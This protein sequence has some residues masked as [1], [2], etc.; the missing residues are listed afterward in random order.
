MIMTQLEMTLFYL[1]GGLLFAL[2]AGLT[3]SQ[4]FRTGVLGSFALGLSA[5]AIITVLLDA[6]SGENYQFL[7]QTGLLVA[8]FALFLL[9][10][11]W[12]AWYH[13][14]VAPHTEDDEVIVFQPRRQSTPHSVDARGF[15]LLEFLL[16]LLLLLGLMVGTQW[17]ATQNYRRGFEAGE[18]KERAAAQGDRDRAQNDYA[19]QVQQLQQRLVLRERQ[20]HQDAARALD[21]LTQEKDNALK[22]KDDVIAA[23]RNGSGSLQFYHTPAFT[24]PCVGYDCVTIPVTISPPGAAR[25]PDSGLPREAEVFLYSQA[26]LADQYTRERNAA[27]DLL[28]AYE[29]A[30]QQ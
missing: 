24:L 25:A 3:L 30:C 11:V 5:Y 6:Y 18:L 15:G 1:L 12:R 21:Q 2:C 13:H 17:W 19:A 14:K 26:A 20:L 16:P 9:Q 7:R 4:C 28:D 10:T 23:L 29:K 27:V 8:G 22:E